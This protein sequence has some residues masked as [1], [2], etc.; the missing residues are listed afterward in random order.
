[1]SAQ[2]GRGG[3]HASLM[4]FSAP[5]RR[6]LE[7]PPSAGGRGHQVH[8]SW[9]IS[10]DPLTSG[11]AA[12]GHGRPSGNFRA[13]RGLDRPPPDV[14]EA[15]STRGIKGCLEPPAWGRRRRTGSRWPRSCQLP[16]PR[17]E[18]PYLHRLVQR[19]GGH[20]GQGPPEATVQVCDRE[21]VAGPDVP[22]GRG[23]G[24]V[25][26]QHA[27]GRSRPQ[28]GG[29]VPMPL[30][31]VPLGPGQTHC[32]RPPHTSLPRVQPL[33]PGALAQPLQRVAPC[34][35]H[36][37]LAGRGTQT[38][39]SAAGRR[40]RRGGRSATCRGSTPAPGSPC[41]PTGSGCCPP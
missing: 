4:T 15:G 20:P 14:L 11:Q 27:A 12:T 37:G 24:R 16:D 21:G 39:C 26:L 19:G 2:R 30:P 17:R 3:G 18:G 13:D 5:L 23:P 22:G 7:V 33:P 34:P 1:M 35:L 8:K 38:T 10:I 40:A 31:P 41:P 25:Y 29:P 36:C 32:P 6:S 9:P 28:G